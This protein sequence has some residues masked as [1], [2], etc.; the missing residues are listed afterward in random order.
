MTAG[1]RKRPVD[2]RRLAREF[3]A[4]L[5]EKASGTSDVDGV[6]VPKK[7]PVAQPRVDTV[8]A[9]VHLAFAISPFPELLRQFRGGSPIVCITTGVDELVEP[10][11]RAVSTCLLNGC[12]KLSQARLRSGSIEPSSERA[13]VIFRSGGDSVR[14]DANDEALTNALENRAVIVAL[15]A[16]PERQLNPDLV[17]AADWRIEL[18]GMDGPRLAATVEA[19]CG[20]G[21]SRDVACDLVQDVRAIDLQ[22]AARGSRVADLMVAR[23]EELVR[24]RATPP[25]SAETLDRLSGF[26][27]ARDIGMAIAADLKAFAAGEL[28]WSVVDRGLLLVGAPG[29]GKTFFAKAFAATADVPLISGSLAVWQSSREGHLGHTLAAMRRSFADARRRAPAVWFID[30]I[31]S[32]G[33]RTTFTADHRDY[34][35]QVVNALLECLDGAENRDGVFVLGATNHPDRIDPALRRSGRLD[36]IVTLRLPELDELMGVARHHLQGELDDA[37]LRE[38][39]V[40]AW[41]HPRR[42]GGLDSAGLRQRASRRSSKGDVGRRPGCD[43]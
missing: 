21:P 26:G 13:Y 31:D 2:P 1:S 30:E 27:A 33:D 24:R 16:D 29:T 36:R 9:A 15:A 10:L 5:F 3:V 35:S 40:A 25:A 14:R 37:G 20:A 43:P 28:S 19:I 4:L 17:R 42:F 11:E 7:E 12:V 38:A 8:V 34:S 22:I 6:D 41:R 39:G 23:V 32:F 18:G